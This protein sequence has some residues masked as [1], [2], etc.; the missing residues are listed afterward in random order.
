MQSGN[1][2]WME[3]LGGWIILGGIILFYSGDAFSLDIILFGGLALILAGIAISIIKKVRS[4]GT[5]ETTKKKN[6]CVVFLAFGF[7]LT[8]LPGMCMPY[9]ET[10]LILLVP[11]VGLSLGLIVVGFLRLVASSI[12]KDKDVR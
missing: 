4:G 12:K 10:A 1:R 9:C 2:N 5:A 7:F 3:I 11:I 8:L 6:N